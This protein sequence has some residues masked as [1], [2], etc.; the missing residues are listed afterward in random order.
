MVRRWCHRTTR[1]VLTEWQP[2]LTRVV[3]FPLFGPGTNAEMSRNAQRQ[4]K[5]IKFLLITK[6]SATVSLPVNSMM[7][8]FHYLGLYTGGLND[9]LFKPKLLTNRSIRSARGTWAA[10]SRAGLHTGIRSSDNDSTGVWPPGSLHTLMQMGTF[11]K[12]IGFLCG[13]KFFAL[14]ISCGEYLLSSLH[15]MLQIWWKPLLWKMCQ[16]IMMRF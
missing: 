9:Q 7:T 13:L 12:E 3:T 11:N 5:L 4:N 10:G 16:W 6:L 15:L 8:M 2:T 14:N 1:T